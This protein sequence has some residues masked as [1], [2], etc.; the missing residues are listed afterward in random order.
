MKNINVTFRVDED[1][2]AQADDLFKDLGMSL[3]TAF[4]IFLRQAVR[5]QKI[6]FTIGREIPNAL[7]TETIEKAE[8][9]ED[10]HGPFE[11]IDELMEALNA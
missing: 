10:M 2:K 5:E 3:S 6:P 8:N 7:T 11:T 9:D 4:T 1:L